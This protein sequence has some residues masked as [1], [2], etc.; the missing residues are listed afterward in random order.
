MAKYKAR[1]VEGPDLSK[2]GLAAE[3]IGARLPTSHDASPTMAGARSDEL[4]RDHEVRN[5]NGADAWAA[6]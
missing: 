3:Q 4:F 5:G 1:T 6:S 2:F